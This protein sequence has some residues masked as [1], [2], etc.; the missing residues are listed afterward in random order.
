MGRNLC[1][2]G[3]RTL[4]SA[5]QARKDP[6]QPPRSTLSNKISHKGENSKRIDT[7]APNRH[8]PPRFN[9]LM[10]EEIPPCKTREL[11]ML[12]GC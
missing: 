8:L 4:R 6:E 2:G 9:P 11:V 12:D 3:G 5:N 1:I 7:M 10:T